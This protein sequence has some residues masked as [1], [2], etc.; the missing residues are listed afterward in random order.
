M[1]LPWLRYRLA[2]AAPVQPLVQ[3]TPYATSGALKS[4]KKIKI[5]IKKESYRWHDSST[6]S[7][8]ERA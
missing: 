2:A 1:A 4:K 7:R 8:K 6:L 3:E 5:K